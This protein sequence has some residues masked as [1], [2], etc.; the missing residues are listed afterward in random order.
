MTTGKF[1]TA[2]KSM[3]GSLLEFE[4]GKGRVIK[5]FDDSVVGMKQGEEKKIVVQPDQGYGDHN[6]AMVKK[7]SRDKN[8]KRQGD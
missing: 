1:L 7:I 8:S 2:L 3:T 4:V 6:P 5:G